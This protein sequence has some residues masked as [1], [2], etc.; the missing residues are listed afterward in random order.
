MTR[1]FSGK[2]L[3][4][5]RSN[6]TTQQK[7]RTGALRLP[8]SIQP[9]RCREPQCVSQPNV[10][11]QNAVLEITATA[12]WRQRA[13]GTVAPEHLENPGPLPRRRR[14]PFLSIPCRSS[15]NL[16]V[17]LPAPT[18]RCPGPDRSLGRDT[19][20]CK[21]TWIITMCFVK[22]SPFGGGSDYSLLL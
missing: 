20:L 13:R 18:A 7:A 14:H 10:T 12:A 3:N 11:P 21:L 17:P 5:Q 8:R 19:G 4:E 9:I 15:A 6:T 22:Q 2:S 16:S 1:A